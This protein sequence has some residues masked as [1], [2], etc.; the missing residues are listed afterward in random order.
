MGAALL[1]HQPVLG[2]VEG[3]ALSVVGVVHLRGA[4]CA[5]GAERCGE[6]QEVQGGAGVQG[7]Q[8]VQGIQGWTKH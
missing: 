6:V 7:V 1:Q 3:E 4:G 2:G 8:G 5:G